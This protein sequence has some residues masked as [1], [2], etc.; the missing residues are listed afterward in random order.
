MTPTDSPAAA[1]RRLR[2]A[3]RRAREAAR[4]TQGHVAEALEWSISKVNRIENGDVTIST[5]DLRALLALLGITDAN[6]VR[7]MTEDARTARKRGWWSDP[8]Y[9][10]HVTADT[11]QL[12]Q[13]ESD[14]AT[15]RC[16]QP[17]LFPGLLQTPDYARAVLSFWTNLTPDEQAVRHEMR[18]RRYGQLFDRPDPPTYLVLL[19]ESVLL[20]EVGGLEVMAEQLVA[21]RETVQHA[22][23]I[24]RIIPLNDGAFLSQ[25][26]DFTIL[27]LPDDENAI[28]YR[29]AQFLENL[30]D[31]SDQVAQYRNTFERMWSLAF[32]Q[33]ESTRLVDARATAIASQLDRARRN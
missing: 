12:I 9:Q 2:L 7:R 27:D 23:V 3:V 30:T 14:A 24:V 15:I 11:L 5:T 22:S 26:G 32:T 10:A 29:E 25:V 31:A 33:D 21:I 20:R 4:L 1:R 13:Y 8:R 6:V 18:L 16:F 17:T 28:L 19:D